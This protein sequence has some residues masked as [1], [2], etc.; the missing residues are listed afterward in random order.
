VCFDIDAAMRGKGTTGGGGRRRNR[1]TM[2]DTNT[3]VNKKQEE[4]VAAREIAVENGPS[5]ARARTTF[6]K[7]LLIYRRMA[8]K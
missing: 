6:E 8:Q 1:L 3:R 2:T 7:V 4:F 5:V